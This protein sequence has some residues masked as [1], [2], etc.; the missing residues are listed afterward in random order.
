MFLYKHWTES[1][2]YITP[3]L[4]IYM[5]MFVFVIETEV[6]LSFFINIK[7]IH[8]LCQETR[9]HQTRYFHS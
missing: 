2:V 1:P 8:L 6:S 9:K 4:P 3:N 7:N 5:G